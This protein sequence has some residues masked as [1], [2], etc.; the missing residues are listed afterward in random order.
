MGDDT[1]I[2]SSAGKRNNNKTNQL[3]ENTEE[4]ETTVNHSTAGNVLHVGFIQCG[5]FSNGQILAISSGS[6]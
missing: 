5:Q 4:D 2:F 3:S 6:V 1:V